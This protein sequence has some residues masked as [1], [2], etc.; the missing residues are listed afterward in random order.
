MPISCQHLVL[1]RYRINNWIYRHTPSHTVLQQLYVICQSYTYLTFQ[2]YRWN[3]VESVERE[4]VTDILS[5]IENKPKCLTNM[6][7][8]CWA[9]VRKV[10]CT[11]GKLPFQSPNLLSVF[12]YI[13]H[14]VSASCLSLNQEAFLAVSI[15]AM[16]ELQ[17]HFYSSQS[18][19]CWFL[20]KSPNLPRL[21]KNTAG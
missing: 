2:N 4:N 10:I 17:V 18:T 1:C 16:E 5:Y 6:D 15:L 11:L 13:P 9:L 12:L 20:G 3:Y 21:S 14:M 7:F 19:Q 8:Q